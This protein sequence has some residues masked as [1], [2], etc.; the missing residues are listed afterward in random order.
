MAWTTNSLFLCNRITRLQNLS[1]AYE[2]NLKNLRFALSD[3]HEAIFQE[4]LRA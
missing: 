2:F 1:I 3:H 4:K